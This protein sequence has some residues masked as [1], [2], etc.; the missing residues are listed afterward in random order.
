MVTT[1]ISVEPVIESAPAAEVCVAVRDV[2]APG[3]PAGVA[4]LTRDAGVEVSWSPSGETDL[5]G[6]RVYRA[7]EGVAAAKLAE[8]PVDQTTFVDPSPPRGK[9]FSYRI[10]A[11]DRAGNESPPS[12]AAE[13]RLQ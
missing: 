9:A 11:V 3:A 1:A 7:A 8:V 6:Y 4:A 10:T 5:A 2:V 13:M 12:A